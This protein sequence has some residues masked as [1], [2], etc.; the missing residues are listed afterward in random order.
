MSPER[1]G[2]SLDALL[3]ALR[4]EPP[5]PQDTEAARAAGQML[6]VLLDGSEAEQALANDPRDHA[7]IE[8]CLREGRLV[9]ADPPTATTSPWRR[10]WLPLWPIPV[11]SL[12]LAGLATLLW[13]PAAVPPA[14]TT[15]EAPAAAWRGDMGRQV[16]TAEDPE[17]T[18]RRLAEVFTQ[19]GWRWRRADADPA[20]GIHLQARLQP[21][22]TA[23]QLRSLANLGVQAPAD[24]RLD[25]LIRPR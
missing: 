13:P 1:D 21:P 5:Q 3:R 9:T 24:G 14:T 4:Q 25:L 7:I 18:A 20:P 2:L 22:P 15:D 11:A 10:W 17:D 8:R 16:V 23:E 19:A 12:A 6:R